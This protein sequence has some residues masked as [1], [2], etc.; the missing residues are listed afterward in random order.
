MTRTN[1]PADTARAIRYVDLESD[2]AACYEL[3]R[4]LRPHL[5]SEQEF[6]ERWR[7]QTSAGYRLLALWQGLKPVALAG[8][9]VQEN[10]VHGQHLYVDDL[11]TDEALRRSGHGH[12][13]MER[14][15]AEARALGCAKLVLDTPL[16]NT[17]G[18]RF[19]Y[20]EGLLATAL[21]FII[22]LV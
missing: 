1:P 18:H 11:V 9:R 19:Y 22:P 16:T 4:Q 21:R 20:R 10:L 8:F 12:A 7:R 13:L 5:P 17:L 3:M 2:A 14:L 6:V 15:K